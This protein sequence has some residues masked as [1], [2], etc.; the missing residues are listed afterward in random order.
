MKDYQQLL[1][2]NKA[3]AARMVQEDPDFFQRLVDIQKPNFLW[4]GCSDSRVPPNEITQTRPG[5]IFIHRNVANLA[6]HTDMNM[7]SVLQY[8]VEVL[9]VKHIVV[10]GHYGCGGVKAAMSRHSFGMINKWLRHI[11]DVYRL[12]QPE[13]LK[14]ANDDQRLNRLIELN[15]QE[16]VNN[17]AETSIVQR[18]WKKRNAPHIHGWVYDLHNGI[19]NP[20]SEIMA[21]DHLQNEIYEYDDLDGI[22]H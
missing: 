22:Q 5:D 14:I 2:A 19:I 17:I 16:Q 4:I 13:L 7:L 10:C 3:W 15:V 21:N 11:K 9:E 1:S 8:A 12:H 6:V 20:I 18:A